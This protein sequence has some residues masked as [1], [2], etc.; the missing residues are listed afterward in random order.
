MQRK[1]MRF[2]TANKLMNFGLAGLFLFLAVYQA[3]LV[4]FAVTRIL[5]G[6]VIILGSG[7]IL[8]LIYKMQV[9]KEVECGDERSMLNGMR[10]NNWCFGL[11]MMVL[12][13]VST[14]GRFFGLAQLSLSW[15]WVYAVIG[16]LYVVTSI[17]FLW[18]ERKGV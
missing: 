5:F 13:V 9:K 11:L 10:A 8:Y 12:I 17:T 18:L 7:G 1:Q 14:A 6:I 3:W 16:M 15:P 2:E 4:Q